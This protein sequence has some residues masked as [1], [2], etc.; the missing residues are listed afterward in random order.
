MTTTPLHHTTGDVRSWA[1]LGQEF[2][3]SP[4]QMFTDDSEVAVR[5]ARCEKASGTPTSQRKRVLN[6]GTR[7]IASSIGASQERE[8][9]NV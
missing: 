8:G 6:D 9:A 5:K 1:P 7:S 3:R 2:H 4:E